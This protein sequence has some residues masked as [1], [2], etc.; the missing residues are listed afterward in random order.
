MN[1]DCSLSGR[2]RDSERPRG[3]SQPGSEATATQHPASF[4]CTHYVS[5]PALGALG[6]AVSSQLHVGCHPRA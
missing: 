4:L 5:S 1:P 3:L 2:G 6:G